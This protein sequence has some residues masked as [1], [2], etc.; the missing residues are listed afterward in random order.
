MAPYSDE[1]TEDIAIS[2]SLSIWPNPNDGSTLGLA[3]AHFDPSLNVVTMDVTDVYGKLVESRNVP[4]QDG[5][6]NTSIAFE[7]VL[8][9]GLYL[10]HLQA[11]S[12]RHTERLVIE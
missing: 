6:L 2:S 5:S 7:H 1:G 10:V 8:A 11:G 12:E 4:V 9:P 3:L